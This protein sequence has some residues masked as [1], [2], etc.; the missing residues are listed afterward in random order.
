MKVLVLTADANTLVYHRGDL[1]RA[2]AR[3]G[4][5]VVT[6]AAEDYP[7]VRAYVEAAGGRHEPI[8]MVR[9]RVNPAKDWI[10][11]L[12]MFRLFRKERPD[13][14]FAYTIKSV[15]Y[16]C[17][18]A[19]LAGVPRVYALLPGLGFTFV[20]PETLKQAVVQW[21]SKALH[22]FALRRADVIFMQNRDDA[23]L[24]EELRL[25]PAGVPVHVTAGSGVNLEEYPH[26]PMENDAALAAGRARFVLV[27]RLLISKGVRIFAEAARR[28]LARFP[29]AE[30]HLVGPFDPN[31]NRVGEAEVAQWVAEG[32]LTHHGMVRDVAAL[33]ET[34]HVFCLPTWYREG[35]PHAT[36]EALATGR[37]VITTDSVG[38]REC[39]RG[40]GPDGWGENGCLVPVRDV[41]AVVRAMERLLEDP[42]LIPRM[43]RASRRLAAEVFDVNFVNDII[44]RAMGLPASSVGVQLSGCETLPDR[45]K[46]ELQHQETT[47][48]Q[49]PA[50]TPCRV[51]AG[52]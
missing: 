9:S 22:R 21:I 10:T 34:M 36:L 3:A 23:R 44:L 2:F 7:H 24:F 13:A 38:A 47:A 12:D 19:R 16:G 30:F 6:S 46:P 28:V 4:C 40:A 5:Q 50:T 29:Q 8:R 41:D 45:L 14:L 32:T 35:V 26:R 39:V 49:T 31:P 52:A 51:A 20:K 43:G 48:T 33:L 18:V 11:W 15:V 1:I 27:S 25:L 42:T 37:P 17:V